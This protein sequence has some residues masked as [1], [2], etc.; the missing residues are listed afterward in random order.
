MPLLPY[1]MSGGQGA[2]YS[3]HSIWDRLRKS[4]V[5]LWSVWITEQD[6]VSERDSREDCVVSVYL[7]PLALTFPSKVTLLTFHLKELIWK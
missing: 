4:T 6:P 5:N 1:C 2:R 7:C 3:D